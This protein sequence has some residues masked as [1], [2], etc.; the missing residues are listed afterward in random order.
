MERRSTAVARKE[1]E[2]VEKCL[3]CYN[4]IRDKS[5]K[6]TITEQGWPKFL[7]DAKRWSELDVD[8]SDELHEFTNSYERALCKNPPGIVSYL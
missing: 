1:P 6:Q 8:S 7:E 3:L 4:I 2:N 5:K